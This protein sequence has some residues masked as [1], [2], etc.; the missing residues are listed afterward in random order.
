MLAKC[1]R[2]PLKANILV[3]NDV[4]AVLC[5]FGVSRFMEQGNLT[6][7]EGFKGTLRWTSPEQLNSE[8]CIHSVSADVW[9]WGMTAL[10]VRQ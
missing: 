7:S 4:R 10:E 8:K 5:D 6:T 9:S 1:M 2:R 3:T